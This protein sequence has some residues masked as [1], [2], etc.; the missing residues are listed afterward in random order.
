[1]ADGNIT[2]GQ[3]EAIAECIMHGNQKVAA[4]CMGITRHALRRR[5]TEAYA[6]LDV[7]GIVDAARV[8]G[9][10]DVP[11]VRAHTGS[12]CIENG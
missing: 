12:G 4:Y 8:L 11:T 3:R 10:V 2:H 5:L 6:T 9:W 1:M 7:P